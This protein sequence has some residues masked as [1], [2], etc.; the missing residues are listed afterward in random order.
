MNREDLQ[1]LRYA[2]LEL[3]ADSTDLV[4]V[5][6]IIQRIKNWWKAKFNPDFAQQQEQ[7]EQAY[8]EMKGP[9]GELIG[10]LKQLDK[11]F[12]GQDVDSIARL[13]GEVPAIISKVTKDMGNL[14]QK[15][16][17]ANKAVPESYVNEKGEEIASGDLS[18][19]MKGFHKDPRVLGGSW[20]LLP[21]EFRNEIPIAQVI[22][23]PLSS[24]SWY[25]QYSPEIRINTNVYNKTKDALINNLSRLFDKTGRFSGQELISKID[26]G[27]D[28]FMDN[29][30]DAIFNKGIIHKVNFSR[31][32]ESVK[33][34]I[35]NQMK[36]EVIIP[37]IPFP[38]GD[39]EILIHT[40][41]VALTDLGTG[42]VANPRKVLSLY[43][44]ENPTLSLSRR[45]ILNDQEIH[46][47]G[48]IT[49]IIK[50]AILKKSLPTTHAIVK[51]NGQTFHHKTQFSRILSSALRQEIDADCS[52]RNDGDDI[53]VQVA[54][55]GSKTASLMAIY[56]ISTYLADEFLNT[57]KIGVG[58]DVV[59]G[60]S[61]LDVIES[62]VFDQS[63]RK[64]A[65]DCWRNNE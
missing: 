11:S 65:F 19:V 41:I 16:L 18:R 51:V 38:F 23:K 7:V 50:R 1:L 28:K 26:S 57:T 34:R 40:N 53:E 62:G 33:N 14:K 37:D 12:Q 45:E 35:N 8:D 42:T 52:V 49:N 2:A 3:Q 59:P 9:L 36:L 30:Q 54:V 4:K 63:F 29:L 58:V 56:G 27:F 39:S 64:V 15:M 24:F 17:D 5:A 46:N 47:A 61:N 25:K 21:E 20:D 22:D 44:V 32:S 60:I 48:I 10:Q 31:P 13:V 55:C 6:G 43:F